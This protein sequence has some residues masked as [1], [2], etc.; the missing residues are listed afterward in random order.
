MGLCGLHLVSDRYRRMYP[1]VAFI[2]I[3]VTF[4]II[5]K[6]FFTLKSNLNVLFL[7]LCILPA[8]ECHVFFLFNTL[9]W[10]SDEEM[11]RL[12]GVPP[13]CVNC[14]S[15]LDIRKST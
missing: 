14:C 7:H 13:V 12:S 10:R 4:S 15:L 1:W 11:P 9:E 5:L 3:T 6:T 8:S 2:F